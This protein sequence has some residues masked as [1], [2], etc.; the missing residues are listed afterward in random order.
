[1]CLLGAARAASQTGAQQQPPMA[2]NVYLDVQVLKGIPVDQFNDTMGMFAAALL[3]DCVGCH[4]PKITSDPKAFALPTPR[5]QRARQMVV[6]MNTLNKMYFGGQQRVTCFTCHGGDPQPEQAPSLRLQYGELVEDP[7]SLKFFPDIAAPPAEKI[8]A[9][10]LQALG[11]AERLAAVTS[12]SAM[13]TYSGFD[14]SDQEVPLDVVARVPNRRAM[15]AHATGAD[16]RWTYDGRSAWK[17][18]PDTPVPLIQLTGWSLTGA[19]V[20]AMVFFPAGIPKAFAQWQ[21]SFA[22]INGRQ[23]EVVRGINPGQSPVNLYFDGSG[24]LVRL[25]RWTQTAAGPVPVQIDY[26]DYREVAGVKMPFGWIMTWTN[27]QSTIKLTDVRPN[28]PIDDR[29]FARPDVA[30]R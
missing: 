22:D 3:L 13:G 27:G 11:G 7:S 2:E 19:G 15:T 30:Q 16:L 8:L 20:D 5:I 17:Y 12:F 9:R 28:V 14:T 25:V 4:D 23:V 6:M 29:A 18:Q 1:V 24:L 26:S 10:Y 21:V